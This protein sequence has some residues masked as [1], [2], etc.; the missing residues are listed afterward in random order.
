MGLEKGDWE[1]LLEEIYP[2]GIHYN[3]SIFN[4]DNIYFSVVDWK[5]WPYE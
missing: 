3:V 5:Y 2:I 4:F 1:E